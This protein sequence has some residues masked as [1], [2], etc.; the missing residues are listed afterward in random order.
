M[1][2][3]RAAAVPYW[4]NTALASAID[5]ARELEHKPI[6]ARTALS[7]GLPLAP[8]DDAD[9]AEG[10]GIDSEEEAGWALSNKQ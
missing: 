9:D 3:L 4:N 7:A 5:R 10:D 8:A 1:R 2:A 6:A